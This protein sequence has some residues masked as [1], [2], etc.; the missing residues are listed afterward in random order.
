LSGEYFQSHVQDQ[1]MPQSLGK[2][3]LIRELGKGASSTVY[4]A[5]DTFT[6]REV[7]LKVVDAALFSDA[8]RAKFTRTQFLNEASLVGKLIHPHIVTMLDACVSDEM[9]YIALEYVPGGNLLPLTDPNYLLPMEHAIEIGFKCCGALDYAY[10]A[11]IIHRDIKPA[12]IM[13]VQGTEIKVADFGAAYLHRSEA[14]QIVD[15]GSPAYMSPEQISGQ[16]LGP[17]SDMFSLAIVLYHLLTGHKPFTASTPIELLEKIRN[18]EP[19]PMESLRKGLPPEVGRV[20]A[21][22][23]AKKPED[24]YP[25]WADFALELAKLGRLS[26]Y[27]QDIPDSKKFRHLREMTMLKSF[28]E[29]EIWELVHASR[30]SRVPAQRPLIREGMPGESLFMLTQGEVKVTKQGRLLNVLRAGECFGEMSYIK[31]GA[32][33]RQASVESITEVVVAEFARDAI[34]K[35]VNASCRTNIIAALLNA[36]VD[37]L[38]LADE[39][40]SRIIN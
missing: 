30:W 38:A 37:R 9:S 19:A 18:E 24:R 27:Q 32:T 12:N 15:I 21:I 23:L 31:G 40:I 28:T 10:R 26:V 1:A 20:I 35:R 5:T 2:Y 22:A 16:T 25:S 6:Q 4:L 29:P 13:V 17:K 14:T 3:E 39:R 34:E 8:R 36:L 11:G 7:A 33:P